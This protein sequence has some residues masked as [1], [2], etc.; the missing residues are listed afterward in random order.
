MM[1]CGWRIVYGDPGAWLKLVGVT[2][3]TKSLLAPM[4]YKCLALSQNN[5]PICLFG[6]QTGIVGD[7]IATIEMENLQPSR[8]ADCK[9]LAGRRHVDI[10]HGTDGGCRHILTGACRRQTPRSIDCIRP[11]LCWTI[12]IVGKWNFW[13]D[14]WLEGGGEMVVRSAAVYE[15]HHAAPFFGGGIGMLKLISLS[16]PLLLRL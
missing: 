2:V 8:S 11:N 7:R 16:S 15:I 14:H 4:A 3:N 13:A 10:D 6:E 12:R 1:L 9:P 5:W